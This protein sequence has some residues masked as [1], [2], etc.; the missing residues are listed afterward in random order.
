MN[1][2]ISNLEDQLLT[3]LSKDYCLYFY[4]MMV[5]SLMILVINI[6]SIVSCIVKTKGK[7]LFR[8]MMMIIPGFLLYFQSRL[9]YSMCVN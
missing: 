4:Y 1:E 2:F 9:F 8:D 3:P 6:L 5:I 7:N